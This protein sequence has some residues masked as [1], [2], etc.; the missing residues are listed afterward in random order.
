MLLFS[1]DLYFP[2]IKGDEEKFVYTSTKTD[3]KWQSE[4]AT[5]MSSAL[6]RDKAT[7]FQATILNILSSIGTKIRMYVIF[8]PQPLSLSVSVCWIFSEK[9]AWFFLHEFEFMINTKIKPSVKKPMSTE[10]E[11]ETE[12]N[13]RLNSYRENQ[14]DGEIKRLWGRDR[15][16]SCAA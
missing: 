14:R 15:K 4:R 7:S 10:K 13:R 12:I 6:N 5:E 9:F 2:F 1:S 16:S 8:F 11:T 3:S